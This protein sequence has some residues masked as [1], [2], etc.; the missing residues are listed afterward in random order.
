[1]GEFRAGLLGWP[2]SHSLSPVIHSIFLRYFRIEGTYE[3]FP[4]EYGDL[5]V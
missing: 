1:M 2:V 5:Q 4:V 3:L